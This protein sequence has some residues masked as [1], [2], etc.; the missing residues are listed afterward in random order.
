MLLSSS[1]IALGWAT[2]VAA[3]PAVEIIEVAK[4]VPD[5]LGNNTVSSIS[6]NSDE[7]HANIMGAWPTDLITVSSEVQQFIQDRYTGAEMTFY[8]EDEQTFIT[9]PE[10]DNSTLDARDGCSG[11][12]YISKKVTASQSYWDSWEHISSCI[13]S[14]KGSTATVTYSISV[15]KGWSADIGHGHM[16]PVTAVVFLQRVLARFG[17][18]TTMDGPKYSTRVALASSAEA[19]P[20]AP[21][22]SQELVQTRNNMAVQSARQMCVRRD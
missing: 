16:G 11:G 2:L 21:S 22:G 7:I 10:G 19:H 12:N 1:I 6:H 3:A 4:D 5:S 14:D 17:V 15:S 20:K 9:V 13:K 18:D 8:L